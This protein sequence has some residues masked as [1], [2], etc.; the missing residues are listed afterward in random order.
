MKLFSRKFRLPRYW[1]NIKASFVWYFLSAALEGTC[2]L[3]GFDVSEQ[4]FVSF[5]L[6][7]PDNSLLISLVVREEEC[8][9]INFL[10]LLPDFLQSKNKFNDWILLCIVAMDDCCVVIAIPGSP[11]QKR[12]RTHWNSRSRSDLQKT[13][14]LWPLLCICKK[15][16]E[17][18]INNLNLDA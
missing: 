12:T 4:G 1:N 17:I 8:C 2:F 11:H 5:L 6:C 18:K 9:R 7:G 13:W 14:T 10:W 15:F 16:P 3:D